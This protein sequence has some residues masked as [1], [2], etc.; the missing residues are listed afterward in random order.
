MMI[1]LVSNICLPQSKS[2]L[3]GVVRSICAKTDPIG[4]DEGVAA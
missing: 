4:S 1:L 2:R 3:Q